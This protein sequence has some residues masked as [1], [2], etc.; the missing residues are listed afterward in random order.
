MIYLLK[1]RQKVFETRVHQGLTI[2]AVSSRFG[3]SMASVI[4]WLKEPTPKMM[5][6]K[7]ATRID[8]ATIVRDVLNYPD[9]F[10]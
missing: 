5:H 3:V 4:L 2:S 8:M 10:H 7:P 1:S 9:A 6:E